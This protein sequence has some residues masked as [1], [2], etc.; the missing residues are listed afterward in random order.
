MQAFFFLLQH[1]CV[2][3]NY[4]V[5]TYEAEIIIFLLIEFSVIMNRY[6]FFFPYPIK[7]EK[8]EQDPLASGFQVSVVIGLQSH[9]FKWKNMLNHL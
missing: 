9:N 8:N 2:K 3:Q 7:G 6:C 4:S 5:Y 1:F